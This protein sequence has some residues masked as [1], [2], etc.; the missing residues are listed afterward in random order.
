MPR[1]GSEWLTLHKPGRFGPL[2]NGRFSGVGL[3]V[4][5]WQVQRVFDRK[6]LTARRVG[7]F[8]TVRASDLPTL[9]AALV[10]AG[11]LEDRG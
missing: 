8:R 5:T 7:R 1:I 3:G 4:R 6:F 9:R 11:Y 2:R 10:Q